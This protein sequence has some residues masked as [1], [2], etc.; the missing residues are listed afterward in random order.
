MAAAAIIND[1]AERQA[2]QTHTQPQP[3][4]E[5]DAFLQLP[6]EL[7][8]SGQ[9]PGLTPTKLLLPASE[10]QPRLR[11]P[12]AAQLFVRVCASRDLQLR[13]VPELLLFQ[14]QEVLSTFHGDEDAAPWQ[15]QILPG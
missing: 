1:R 8:E 7:I 15:D 6:G 9:E 10:S 11:K 2:P 12:W 3:E 14:V 5:Q 4:L 13:E